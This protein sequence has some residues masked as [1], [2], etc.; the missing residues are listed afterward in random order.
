MKSELGMAGLALDY[1]YPTTGG[2]LARAVVHG[3]DVAFCPGELL[4]IVGPNGA[5]KSTVLKLLAGLIEP[6]AGRVVLDGEPLAALG[7]RQ[8]ARRV[9]RVPQALRSL[10]DA[11]VDDFVAGGRYAHR[12]PLGRWSADD[13]RA[14]RSALESCDLT[15]FTRRPLSELSGGERQRVLIARALG[16]E[17]DVLLVDEPTNS[18]DPEHQVRV[19]DLLRQLADAGHAVAVVTH[20]LALAGQY[21]SNV[22]VLRE[23]AVA[24][25]GAPGVVLRRDVLED[26]YGPHLLYGTGPSLDGSAE[27]PYVV[28]WRF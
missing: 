5:G 28:P 25:F 1:A 10:P 21:S 24:A 15:E 4:S 18:L 12:G 2:E 16:Q 22:L 26:V 13:A 27:R 9:A 20:E 23:G 7:P 8:R 17:A 19:F 6:D 14:L 11:R 3:V